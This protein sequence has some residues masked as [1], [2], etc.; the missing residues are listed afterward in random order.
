LNS[1]V[2]VN[3]GA[4]PRSDHSGNVGTALLGIRNLIRGKIETVPAVTVEVRDIVGRV[5]CDEVRAKCN[6]PLCDESLRDGF[7]VCGGAVGADGFADYT[8]R[9]EIPAG[10]TDG[11]VLEDGSAARIFTGAAIPENGHRVVPFEQCIELD[12]RIKIASDKLSGTRTFIDRAGSRMSSGE[13]IAGKGYRFG[14]V[15]QGLLSSSGVSQVKVASSPRVSCYCT[16]SE[17][18]EP[19]GSI[20]PG[21]KISGNGLQLE[22]LIPTFG[23]LVTN[24]AIV[25]DDRAGMERVLQDLSGGDH[26]LVVTTGG[27]GP[28][29]YDLVQELFAEAGGELFFDHLPLRPGKALLFGRL[30][31]TL[32]IALPGPPHA[33]R[34]LIHELVGPVLLLMQGACSPW[35]EPVRAFLEHEVALKRCEVTQLKD[36]VFSIQDGRCTVRLRGRL[37]PGN[38]ILVFTKGRHRYPREELIEV[39][40]LPGGQ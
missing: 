7:V 8:V 4:S 26:D 16:G 9:G 17:L 18:V 6:T 10:K 14:L 22:R 31:R 1:S 29:K 36:G 28:G 40:L 12:D 34:T 5:S 33:V 24:C 20:R 37:E 35:P 30:G 32:F 21:Q 13:V 2:S 27:M 19:G 11:H 39:H 3:K 38:C 15:E 23:G 25:K